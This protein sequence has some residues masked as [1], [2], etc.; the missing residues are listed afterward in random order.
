MVAERFGADREAASRACEREAARFAGVRSLAGFTNAERLAWV[1]WSP[2][3]VLLPGIER[4]TTP[5]KRALV[6]VVKAKGGPR[7]SDFV[8]RFDR[9]RRLRGSLRAL[10]EKAAARLEREE[11]EPRG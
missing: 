7:E 6:G 5:E 9:H 4:W 10:A 11:R 3:I 1:R 8:L 2:V